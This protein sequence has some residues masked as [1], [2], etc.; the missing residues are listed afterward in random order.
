MS[1]TLINVARPPRMLT[2]NLDHIKHRK[3]LKY[4]KAVVGKRG[5]TVLRREGKE[6]GDSIT[7]AA[8]GTKGSSRGGLPD[9]ILECSEIKAAI[10]ARE[11]KA[12]QRPSPKAK[13]DPPPKPAAETKPNPEPTP[14]KP[15]ASRRSSSK[16][17][18]E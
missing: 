6:I 4:L 1:V 2:Y 3:T 18:K 5:E 8:R 13:P 16:A 17:G 10:A 7:L 9:T 14:P 11:I 15:K 12:D